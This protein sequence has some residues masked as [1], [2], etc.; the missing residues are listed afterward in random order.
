M[1]NT[2]RRLSGLLAF[3]FILQTMPATVLAIGAVPNVQTGKI[4]SIVN[5]VDGP[6]QRPPVQLKLYRNGLN[7][8]DEADKVYKK[9]QAAYDTAMK[10]RAEKLKKGEAVS[11]EPTKPIAPK[12]DPLF[13]PVNLPIE[14]KWENTWNNLPLQ[15]ADG[16]LKYEYSIR[17]SIPAENYQTNIKV[18]GDSIQF[19]NTYLGELPQ[20]QDGNL[21]TAC[22]LKW[23]AETLFDTHT[24]DPEKSQTQ[25]V[26]KETDGVIEIQAATEKDQLHWRIPIATAADV[27]DAQLIIKLPEDKWTY[28]KGSAV[29][30]KAAAELE[31]LNALPHLAGYQLQPGEFEAKYED[32]TLTIEIPY[33]QAKTGV[34]LELVGAAKSGETGIQSGER[35]KLGAELTGKYKCVKVNAEWKG[36]EA[37]R[38][39]LRF[40]LEQNRKPYG[41]P[42]VI[43]HP[44]MTTS[45]SRLPWKLDG[46]WAEYQVK[47]ASELSSYKLEGEIAR[48]QPQSEM[49]SPEEWTANFVF[50]PALISVTGKV[51]WKN[52][53]PGALPAVYFSLHRQVEGEAAKPVEGAQNQQ[54]DTK[55]EAVWRDL[56][57][58]DA[59]GKKYNYSVKEVDANG[60]DFTPHGYTKTEQGLYVVNTKAEDPQPPKAPQTADFSAEVLWVDAPAE[61]PSVWL[62]LYRK[63]KSTTEEAVPELSILQA[64]AAGAKVT[65]EN[66][67]IQDAEG[68]PYSYSVK[69]VDSNG[70]DYT[71]AGYDKV[72]SGLTVTNTRKQIPSID[73]T[74]EKVWV[75]AP[76]E[77]PTIWLKLYRKTKDTAATA[78][79]G[80]ELLKFED[81]TTT[82]KWTGL[83]K[84]DANGAEYIYEAR[85]VN[86]KGES[87][88]PSGYVKTES[89]LKVTNTWKGAAGESI[90]ATKKWSGGITPRPTIWFKLY[91][92]VSGGRLEA[93]PNTSILK[94]ENGTTEV[95]WTGLD[96]ADADGK[97]YTYSVKEVNSN[98]V[99]FTPKNYTKKENGLTVTNTYRTSGVL[100][101]T[102]FEDPTA[103]YLGAGMLLLGA[104]LLLHSRRKPK[105][106]VKK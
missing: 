73:V 10:D 60:V 9:E 17:E 29:F 85:E 104:G 2:I 77:V 50:E 90:K 82:A 96:K 92:Q 52:A 61:K 56:P 41:E 13:A 12:S 103:L 98:G 18:D 51:E 81:G 22:E 11:A 74:A 32:N 84:T 31:K 89:G 54:V 106:P 91:R 47:L 46:D 75:N 25:R 38:P 57:E 21:S 7:P 4:T 72:E 43:T 99:E 42:A 69:Q 59:S 105:T 15:S 64:G 16:K 83:D 44:E 45:W 14:G 68:N 20:T 67:P 53:D 19:I 76:K 39:E 24:Q 66:L 37:P 100:P 5:W 95:V 55:G 87:H 78:V 63:T 36:G 48:T 80:A 62:K 3:W 86:E 34:V 70:L 28:T 30:V 35:F 101:R 23:S 1:K 49:A 102:G 33:L 97:V 65:W 88:T 40:G 26:R 27:K 94:L 93:V 79:P 8:N 58:F 6:E 71:P